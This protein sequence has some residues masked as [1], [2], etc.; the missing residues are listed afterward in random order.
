MGLSYDLVMLSHYTIRKIVG[1]NLNFLFFY[2]F[3]RL[4]LKSLLGIVNLSKGVW[5]KTTGFSVKA[6]G[7]NG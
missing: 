7:V 3:L 1:F 4:Q 2:F 6:L 5:N